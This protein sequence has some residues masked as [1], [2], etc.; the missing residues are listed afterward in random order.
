MYPMLPVA[1]TTQDDLA[2]GKPGQ[3]DKRHWTDLR[4]IAGR[5]RSTA[6]DRDRI[7]VDLIPDVWARLILFSN[8]L[9]NDHHPLHKPALAAY[10]GFLALLALR[11]RKHV[12]LKSV[13]LDLATKGNWPFSAAARQQKHG[14]HQLYADTNWNEIYLLRGDG[15][16]LLGITSPLTLV[17][18]AQGPTLKGLTQLPSS[19]FSG[20]EFQDPAAKGVL[21]D[22]DRTLLAAWV[23]E[24]KTNLAHYGQDD[25][26]VKWHAGHGALLGLLSKFEEDLGG[27]T[28]AEAVGSH[29]GSLRLGNSA[30]RFLAVGVKAEEARLDNSDLMLETSVALKA[31]LLLPIR[32]N[33]PDTVIEPPSDPSK[34]CV[35]GG[36][37]LLDINIAV[38][39]DNR[40]SLAGRPLPGDAEWLDPKTLFLDRLFFLK[41]SQQ[42]SG[43]LHARGQRDVADHFSEYPVLPFVPKLNDLLTPADIVRNVRFSIEEHPTGTVVAVKLR[44]PLKNGRAVEVTRMYSSDQQ[45][46][47][48][49][50]PVLEVWPPFRRKGWTH[51]NT[52]WWSNSDLTF[53]ADPFPGVPSAVEVESLP[54]GQQIRVTEMNQPPDG[55]L[56]QYPQGAPGRSTMQN[57][58]FVLLKFAEITTPPTGVWVAGVDFGTSSTNIISHGER[59]RETPL[60]LTQSGPLRVVMSRDA[61]RP[62]ALYKYFLPFAPENA[63]RAETSP[64]LSF[65]RMRHPEKNEF[66]EISGAHVFFYS[67]SHNVQELSSGRLAT[68]LK[69]EGQSKVRSEPYLRQVCLQTA[70]E[71]AMGGAEGI[72]WSYSLPT[73]F[74]RYMRGEYRKVWRLISRFIEESTGLHSTQE[75]QQMTES[76]ANAR[77]FT[78][79]EEAPPVVGAVFMDI[80]G[81]TTDISIWQDNV[82]RCGISIR[83][84]GRDI[85]LGPLYH[86]R[87]RL[88][89]DFTAAMPDRIPPSQEA[90]LLSDQT[91]DDFF[92]H[93]EAMLRDAGTALPQQLHRQDKL[94]AAALPVRIGLAGLFY[95]LGIVL[96]HL[97][98]K[99]LYKRSLGGVFVG[100]NGAQLLHWADGGEYDPGGAFAKVLTDCLFAGARWGDTAP[101]NVQIK[102]SSRPKQEVAVGLVVQSTLVD[103]EEHWDDVIA[104]EPFTVDGVAKREIDLIANEDLLRAEVSDLP[105]LRAFFT[106]YTQATDSIGYPRLTLV[107]EGM[108]T[109]A[110]ERVRQ[111]MANQRTQSAEEIELAPPF[112][113]G[114]QALCI[115]IAKEAD[116]T[117]S[118]KLGR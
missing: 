10:R 106:A 69:W 36:T 94:E 53:T 47:I 93:A 6:G 38:W 95:Y 9:F 23:H 24:L 102:L 114:L 118:A 35:V 75:P 63:E 72:N 101:K 92:A 46:S 113:T 29:E 82:E 39:G 42:R 88:I 108:F 59:G 33:D 14:V 16:S 91:E 61:D 7:E 62:E 5:T 83:F 111:S 105:E 44:L 13:A 2:S 112:I 97:E 15:G 30:Y 99:G 19:W 66:R 20:A 117:R 22:E 34:L 116:R 1:E 78:H 56:L 65:L 100:G 49:Q 45:T 12:L 79:R 57:A 104:G 109:R 41:G 60:S 27:H 76:F 8:A 87:G 37:S 28:R 67:R 21:G 11:I 43:L 40:R 98:E 107:N 73:A 51:Y 74:S 18:P 31:P 115:G 84:A 3:W 52:F 77:Y 86:L 81:G 110:I 25:A 48:Q 58:G 71:A 54:G 26:A 80:G 17:C 103:A 50:I 90:R 32:V 96:R 55:F 4:H 85:F 70:A 68:N 89:K 64:F